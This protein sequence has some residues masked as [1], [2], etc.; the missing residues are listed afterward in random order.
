MSMPEPTQPIQ[1]TAAHTFT[2]TAYNV[3]TA[4]KITIILD[5]EVASLIPHLTQ[6]VMDAASA[7][8]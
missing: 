7:A 2:V 6:L 1:L 8:Q 4:G 5:G 3:E